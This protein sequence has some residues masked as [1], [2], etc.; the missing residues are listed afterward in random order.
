APAEQEVTVRLGS[1]ANFKFRFERLEAH[2]YNYTEADLDQ[3]PDLIDRGVSALRESASDFGLASHLMV[4]A[5]HSV[6]RGVSS[7]EFLKS[8]PSHFDLGIGES[9]GNGLI[10]HFDLV[11][12]GW[13]VQLTLDHS[14]SV[15]DGIYMNYTVLIN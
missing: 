12:R 11:D 1:S 7:R 15:P 5:S 4:H 6:L 3:L 13:K 14:L 10:F 8:L 2:L 9:E